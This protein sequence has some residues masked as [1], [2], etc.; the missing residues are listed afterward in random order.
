MGQG[1]KGK[2]PPTYELQVKARV[3]RIL[4]ALL[5]YFNKKVEGC[6]DLEIKFKWQTNNQ[7]ATSLTP[8]MMKPQSSRACLETTQTSSSR[9][10]VTL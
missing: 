7:V 3:E 8:I 5:S 9:N 6:E 1:Q 4:E 10:F 2:R